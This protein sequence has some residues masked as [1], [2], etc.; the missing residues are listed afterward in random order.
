[1]GETVR[2]K[3]QT[4]ESDD[5]EVTKKIKKRTTPEGDDDDDLAPTPAPLTLERAANT[6]CALKSCPLTTCTAAVRKI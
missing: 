3:K 2:R 4:T 5:D 6:N 1:M